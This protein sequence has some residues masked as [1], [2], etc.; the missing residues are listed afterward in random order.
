MQDKLQYTTSFIAFR[1]AALHFCEN[2][3]YEIYS[4]SFIHVAVG[5]CSGIT[6]NYSSGN[7]SFNAIDGGYFNLGWTSGNGARRIIICKAGSAPGFTPQNG[8]DYNSSDV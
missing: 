8:I 5:G 2:L 4:Y 3:F 1:S 7:L 6:T